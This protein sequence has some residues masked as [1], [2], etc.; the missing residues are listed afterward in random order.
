LQHGAGYATTE[1]AL[2]P[3][4]EI[5]PGKYRWGNHG[6]VYR[7]RAAAERQAAAIF[8]SGYR[9][10]QLRGLA[11][12]VKASHRAE[13]R[14]ALDILRV[15]GALHKAAL[16]VVHREMH[17]A[18]E[19]DLRQD[20][21]PVALPPG[22]LAVPIVRQSTTYSCG[23]AAALAVL[24]YWL[25]NW[26]AVD[27][28]GAL[29]EALD[30]S[31]ELGTEPHPIEAFLLVSGLRATYRSTVVTVGD[32]EAAV[33]RGE[34][35]IICLQ[36]YRSSAA[37]WSEQWT[38]GHY[39][40]VIG[41]DAERVFVM[42]PSSGYAYVPRAELDE[43]WHDLVGR[44]DPVKTERIAIFASGNAPHSTSFVDEPAHRLDAVAS[45]FYQDAGIADAKRRIQKL[46]E[47]IRGW[48]RVH[49]VAA[50]NRMAVEVR[51]H[52][53]TGTK[54]LGIPVRSVPGLDQ[55][56]DKAREANVA[57]ITRASQ[58]FL[59]QVRDVLEEHAN[60]PA[61]PGAGPKR[62]AKLRGETPEGGEPEE[63]RTL[64]E[65]LQER[66][67]VSK[68]RAQLIARDQTTK[69]SAALTEH[70]QKAA[71]VSRFVWSTSNDERVRKTHQQLHGKTFSWDPNKRADEMADYDISDDDPGDPAPTPG[72][73]ILC[74]CVALPLLDDDISEEPEEQ[75]DEESTEAG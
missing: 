66:V 65:A 13:S 9:E 30:T 26:N 1:E 68:S 6:K 54:L 61:G 56:I 17:G 29:F 69:L 64:A 74:R 34:P 73:P 59:D 7:S 63:P 21:G 11:I 10:D 8:A 60:L 35:P 12:H 20:S 62:L 16:M 39:V 36:A 31:P 25:P 18:A 58:S 67:G 37:P 44:R 14:Y 55:M 49:T 52:T 42:D 19:A 71:G 24:R 27:S 47:Q 33:A 46:W 70:R 41:F 40:V 28:D 72:T 51:T 53:A 3:V 5:A 43:R 2:M 23:P 57:L 50:F 4:R 22:T 38:A 48:I 32:L 45:R 15:M 75:P